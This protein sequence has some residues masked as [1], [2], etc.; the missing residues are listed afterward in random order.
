ME[1]PFNAFWDAFPRKHGRSEAEKAF[2]KAIRDGTIAEEI[3]AAAERFRDDPNLPEAT[4]IPQGKSWLS[5]KRW[6]D[7]PLPPRFNRSWPSGRP[8]L[9]DFTNLEGR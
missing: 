3:I 7:P 2:A 4:F 9:I 6:C 5:Q 1:S 8:P